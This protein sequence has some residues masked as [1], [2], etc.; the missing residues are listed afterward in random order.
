MIGSESGLYFP[1]VSGS[2][3]GA[4]VCGAGNSRSSGG[5]LS[6]YR[7]GLELSLGVTPEIAI[8]ETS[9]SF[10]LDLNSQVG[11]TQTE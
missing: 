11:I 2:G 1:P 5:L 4:G 10:N 8:K 7:L 9:T 6:S 3:G